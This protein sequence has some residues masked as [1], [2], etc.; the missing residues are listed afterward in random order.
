MLTG[1]PHLERVMTRLDGRMVARAAQALDRA[2]GWLLDAWGTPAVGLWRDGAPHLQTTCFAVLAA[3]TLGCIPA[4]QDRHGNALQRFVL[5]VERDADGLPRMPELHRRELTSHSAT[6]IRLQTQYFLLH[7]GD[8]LGFKVPL[9]MGFLNRLSDK[10]YL[11]GWLD[12]G[13]WRNPWLHSNTIMFALT[14]LQFW[15]SETGSAVALQRLDDILDYLDERQDAESGLWQPDD[16]PDMFNALYAAYH[17]WPYYFWRS[18]RPR[19]TEAIIDSTLTLQ[20]ADGLFCASAG[21]GACEDLDAIHTLVMMSLVSEHRAP[22]VR[23]ALIKALD[24]MLA[25]QSPDGGFRNYLHPLPRKTLKRRVG[26]SIGLDRL[27]DKPLQVGQWHL[28]GMR[29]YSCPLTASDTW[30]AWFR[31]LA[32]RLI[33][34]RYGDTPAERFGG[35]YR[36]QPGLGWHDALRIAHA[37]GV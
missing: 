8:A 36:Q 12:A 33:L 30:A 23:S 25:L 31:P 20:H 26:E 1:H 32:I 27:L 22:E 10:S 7:S 6:Y 15:W 29:R 2:R 19:Y 4:I 14:F 24:V 16:G 21:G 17:F 35:S 18:R 34:D 11:L 9:P 5:D 37:R 13:P 28:S 3:E